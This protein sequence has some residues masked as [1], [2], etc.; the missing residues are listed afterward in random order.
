ME[1]LNRVT[2][3]ALL[4][5]ASGAG[6]MAAEAGLWCFYVN[7]GGKSC[8]IVAA[9]QQNGSLKMVATVKPDGD[10]V[11]LTEE[12]RESSGLSFDK[13]VV[14]LELSPIQYK[15]LRTTSGRA[16]QVIRGDDCI[17]F[18]DVK[19][20]T[21]RVAQSVASCFVVPTIATIPKDAQGLLSFVPPNQGPDNRP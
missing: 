12:A 21:R 3:V 7:D 13:V 14:R 16:I 8:F 6:L 5:L 9:D 17:G 2:L 18:A 1:L 4:S 19:L 20:G 11:L 10:L 15:L